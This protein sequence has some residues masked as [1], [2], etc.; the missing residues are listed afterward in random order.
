MVPTLTPLFSNTSGLHSLLEEH[1][2][3]AAPSAHAPRTLRPGARSCAWCC[4]LRRCCS[5]AKLP[6]RVLSADSVPAAVAG[7]ARSLPLASALRAGLRRSTAWRSC[8][9]RKVFRS[10]LRRR[11]PAQLVAKRC[12]ARELQPIVRAASAPKCVLCS[13]LGFVCCGANFPL[14]LNT[15]NTKQFGA[16]CPQQTGRA[17]HG[18]VVGSPR[19]PHTDA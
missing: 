3:A 13:I 10:R 11:P 12:H 6:G 17:A 8:H 14:F 15:Y 16:G 4:R 18:A 1:G 9:G 2:G 5:I 19:P 7:A